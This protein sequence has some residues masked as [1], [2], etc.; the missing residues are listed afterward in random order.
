MRIVT[1]GCTRGGQGRAR[2]GSIVGILLGSIEP[3][4]LAF[5]GNGEE[6]RG[7]GFDFVRL[8]ASTAG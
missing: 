4:L 1:E 2:Q 3:G 8:V 6:R 5:P 7:R